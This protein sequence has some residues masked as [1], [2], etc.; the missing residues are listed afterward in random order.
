MSCTD[1]TH[2][3]PSLTPPPPPKKTNGRC[4]QFVLFRHI[5]YSAPVSFSSNF[6]SASSFCHALSVNTMTDR[7]SFIARFSYEQLIQS[8]VHRF[9]HLFC[10]SNINSPIMKSHSSWLA[11]I[12]V[13]IPAPP[14]KY[15]RTKLTWCRPSS[16]T[17][18]ISIDRD[19]LVVGRTGHCG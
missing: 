16:V 11:S 3:P 14:R 17:G 18:I 1:R 10:C 4:H 12:G 6:S 13:S 2:H 9:I 8:P 5:Y 7:Q 19:K 15:I